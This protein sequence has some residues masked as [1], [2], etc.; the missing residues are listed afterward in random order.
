MKN[1]VN[2]KKTIKRTAVAMLAAVMTM[3]TASGISASAADASTSY[4]LFPIMTFDNGSI[5]KN[6]REV[7]ESLD[8]PVFANRLTPKTYNGCSVI[9]GSFK[10]D[11]N[12]DVVFKYSDGFFKNDPYVYDNHL[13]TVSV[14]F[15]EASTTYVDNKST[16]LNPDGTVNK[17]ANGSQ[18]IEYVLDTCGFKDI[19]VSDSY[20]VKPT[21][22]SIACA[23][24]AKTADEGTILSITVRSASYEAEWA[25]NVTLGTKGEA[26]GFSESAKTVRTY[27]NEY[28][29][30]HDDVKKD[31]DNGKCSIWI[32]GFS[33]GGAVANLTAKGLVDD[34]QP[35]GNKVFAYTFETPR[36]GVKSEENKDSDYSC[37]HNTID[38]NDFVTYVAPEEMGFK[39]YGEDHYVNDIPTDK[40]T[41]ELKKMLGEE[42]YKGY[43]PFKLNGQNTADCIKSVMKSVCKEVSR[44][45]YV[46]SGIQDACRR[47]MNFIFTNGIDA[48][49][50]M[51]T[52]DLANL[53]NAAGP[54]VK[55]ILNHP[56]GTAIQKGISWLLG[57][58]LGK[59]ID[60][61][62]TVKNSILTSVRDALK[63]DKGLDDLFKKYE[64]GKNAMMDDIYLVLDK[65]LDAGLGNI[66]DTVK[67]AM[68]FKNIY[69]N[70]SMMQTLAYMRVNDTWYN[71]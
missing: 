7:L 35:K 66:G 67:L 21:T 5:T 15:A 14:A 19:E 28:I 63:N 43:V 46:K 17:Y 29:E 61:L 24:G 32:Q 31:I 47:L 59:S 39:R 57:P 1:T 38:K 54:T 60:P 4:S 55:S 3:T 12:F 36:G 23:F 20:K 41:E 49:K 53:L 51:K 64:G 62:Y 44:T 52:V 50:L 25:S 34:Y 22:D 65:V 9:E 45:D 16:V 58:D 26:E 2:T 18:R 42:N 71:A 70:H 13:A 10:N 6:V 27:L 33:R 68:N 37:I 48:D 40:V 69:G 30:N 56:V 8:N 11:N